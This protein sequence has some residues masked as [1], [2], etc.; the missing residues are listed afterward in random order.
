MIKFI[1]L[2]RDMRFPVTLD[3]IRTHAEILKEKIL[4]RHGVCETAKANLGK[5]QSSLGWCV[6]FI[7]HRNLKSKVLY[8]SAGSAGSAD[9]EKRESKM[10][11][12]RDH[13]RNYPLNKIFNV[14]ETA[15][16]YKCLPRWSYFLPKENYNSLRGTKAMRDWDRIT[17]ILCTSADGKT[18]IPI[19]IIGVSKNPRA[20]ENKQPLCHYFSSRKAWSNKFLFN[21]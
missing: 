12:L 5:F 13:L 17:G 1:E 4:F 11:E 15:L 10:K 18:K 19:T 21:K 20:F 6:R 3:I 14:D 9:V 2:C 16:F 7:N 8:G